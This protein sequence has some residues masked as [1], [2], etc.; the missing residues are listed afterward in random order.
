MPA[1]RFQAQR[2]DRTDADRGF[3]AWYVPARYPLPVKLSQHDG[4]D[5]TMQLVS[6]KAAD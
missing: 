2:V 1:G 5:L 3:S 4:G 6:F